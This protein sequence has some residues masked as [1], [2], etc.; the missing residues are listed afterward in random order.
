M[1]LL[2]LL[3]VLFLLV[4][5]A[6]ATT[7]FNDDGSGTTDPWTDIQGA[8]HGYSGGRL[9]VTDNSD[10]AAMGVYN[11]TA[12]FPANGS[13]NY[14]AR[15]VQINDITCTDPTSDEILIIGLGNSTASGLSAIYDCY[16]TES[17]N[18]RIYNGTTYTYPGVAFSND[19]NLTFTGSYEE[20]TFEFFVNGVSIESGFFKKQGDNQRISMGT[21]TNNP[22]FNLSTTQIFY[23][24]I[25]TN[26]I[27]LTVNLPTDNDHTND[28]PVNFTFNVN[29]TG[30]TVDACQLNV[31][32]T[33]ENSS[34]GLTKGD[35]F[36]TAGLTDGVYTWSIN[37]TDEGNNV[38][39]PTRT[40]Y[41][42]T[43]NPL[44]TFEGGNF[45]AS[46]NTTVLDKDVDNATQLMNLSLEDTYIFAYNVTIVSPNGSYIYTNQSTGVNGSLLNFT[47]EFNI[48]EWAEGIYNV[49][50]YAEDDHTATTIPDYASRSVPDGR[51]WTTDTGTTITVTSPG[52]SISTV[53]EGDRYT[54]TSDAGSPRV[55]TIFLLTSSEPLYYRGSLYP[56]P[57]FVT[58]QHWVDFNTPAATSYA[59]VDQGYEDGV[60]K[61][62]VRVNTPPAQVLEFR[63]LGG[64]N[65]V[66]QSYYFEITSSN[67]YINIYDE[68][69]GEVITENV[70]ITLTND[71]FED[72]VY[73]STGS[74]EY[75]NLTNGAYS[76]KLESSSYSLRTY[77]IVKNETKNFLNAYLTNSTSTV[78]FTAKDSSTGLSVEGV[79]TTMYKFV[80]GSL[81]VV[82]S[83]YSDVTGRASYA[84]KEGLKYVFFFSKTGYEAKNFTL[85]PILFATYDVLLEPTTSETQSYADV[86][87]AYTPK[88]YVNNA[89]NNFTITFNSPAGILSSYSY[90]VSY[91]GGSASGNGNNN[92]GEGFAAAFYVNTTRLLDSVNV[93]YTYTTVYG[94]TKTFRAAHPITGVSNSNTLVK[95]REN[96]YGLGI[97][98]RILIATVFTF[99][100]VGVVSLFANSMLGAVLGLFI[101]GF[102]WWVGFVPLIAFL[103][104]VLAGFLLIGKR[105]GD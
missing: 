34:T 7:Y 88:E 6:T 84:Y 53:K 52:T 65:I 97:L 30:S 79:G 58:G 70:T 61:Y 35:N 71:E 9:F 22:I 43:V 23:N 98:E 33:V 15:E 48:S 3:S 64:L 25:D 32:G 47:E 101:M 31:N 21:W 24:E 90:T 87:V 36:Y 73:T 16:G 50:L 38:T 18:F 8:T 96:Q 13:F 55:A 63:S 67:L 46:D 19:D 77:N 92:G 72:V 14:T 1:K 81:V 44:W 95:L 82:E 40:L 10:A 105:G 78:V 37:C 27:N 86:T 45:F 2:A 29:A 4:P 41:V 103:I 80:N 5:L 17:G 54:F 68:E 11:S 51:K 62:Q 57:V 28:N 85:D 39:S 99:I 91:P 59:V 100:A 102:F 94:E 60:Y 83:K 42:D 69:T 74:Y 20:F 26:L 49:T 89:T 93:T 56:F 76:V 12:S 104:T 75:S 66:N